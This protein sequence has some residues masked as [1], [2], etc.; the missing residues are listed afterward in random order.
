MNYLDLDIDIMLTKAR[1]VT[2]RRNLLREK[3]ASSN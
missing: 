3:A 2:A 1:S